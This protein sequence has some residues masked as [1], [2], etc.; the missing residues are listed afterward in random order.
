MVHIS[1]GLDNPWI[2]QVKGPSRSQPQPKA[3]KMSEYEKLLA[4][5]DKKTLH[6]KRDIAIL[7]LMGDGGLRR[8]EVAG[9]GFQD[10]EEVARA[11]DPELRT[12]VARKKAEATRHVVHVR[13]GKRGKTRSVPLTQPTIDALRAWR[14]ARP[15]ADTES[16][17][18]SLPKA[19][20]SQPKALTA[21]AVDK[22][23]ERHAAQTQLPDDR[24]TPHVLRHTFCTNLAERGVALEV[25]A[26]LAG[27]SDLRTT[28]QYVTV[29][30][31]RK[32]DAI[33]SLESK[34]D[35]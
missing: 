11:K 28:L 30:E 23:V 16:L 26:E 27:H 21:R 18:L 4:V 1:T 25:I 17:L 31:H 32:H 6:G 2:E 5:P 22:L 19:K 8:S 12:A 20:Y 29:R 7:R 10:I 35:W 3:L 14:D 24:R 15:P 33:S 13:A 9:L 34:S